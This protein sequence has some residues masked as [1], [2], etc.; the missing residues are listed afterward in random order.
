MR[1]RRVVISQPM[2]FPWVGMLEQIMLADIY[3]H[4]A[5]VQ[6]SKGSF[7]NRVQVKTAS[8]IKWLT[9]PLKGLSL[10]QHIDEV[11]VSNSNDWRGNHIQLLAQAYADAPFCEEMLTIVRQTYDV[12]IKTIDEL[13]IR[14]L[15][16]VIAYFDLAEN[17]QFMDSRNMNVDGSSSQRVL[18]IIR[19]VGGN[20]YITGHG[21]KKYLDH[22]LFEQNRIRVEYMD[23]QKTSYPQLHGEFTP[24]VS[25]L[26]LIANVGKAGKKYIH[27]GTLY[28]RNCI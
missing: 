23:Y 12:N 9:L 19:A 21:A 22:E 7:V 26:D 13:A 2:F 17:T 10:G 24:Y 8:G 27:S 11:E 18:D 5:D 15:N 25:I 20:I 4:Y 3:V 14:S 1:D 16:A 6:F 28:W